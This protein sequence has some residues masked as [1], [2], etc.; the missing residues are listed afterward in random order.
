[1]APIISSAPDMG[2][3]AQSLDQGPTPPAGLYALDPGPAPP[4]G[5]IEHVR[6]M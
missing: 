5:T 6:Y 4:A 1:M 3:P 2:Q